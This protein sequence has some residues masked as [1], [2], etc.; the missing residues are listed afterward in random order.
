MSDADHEEHR[1][2]LAIEVREEVGRELYHEVVQRLFDVGLMLDAVRSLAVE[3]EIRARIEEAAEGLDE[4]IRHIRNTLWSAAPAPP[5]DVS[6]PA[7]TALRILVVDD[8]DDMRTLLATVLADLGTIEVKPDVPQAL[9]WI[10][11]HNVDVVVLDLLFPGPSGLTL[12]ESLNRQ[13]IPIPVVVVSALG[14]R[15]LGRRASEAGAVVVVTKPFDKQ[16][17]RDNVIE[18]ARS[19]RTK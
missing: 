10:T 9:E 1:R 8:D 3:A 12:L 2:R 15:E 5:S 11:R 17:L 16:L 6:P 7:T 4:T 14:D 13:G 19:A 18:A